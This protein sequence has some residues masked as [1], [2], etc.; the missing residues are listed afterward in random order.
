MLKLLSDWIYSGQIT[1][2]NEYIIDHTFFGITEDYK[3]K[4]HTEIFNFVFQG[5]GGFPYM[6]VYNMPISI[7]NFYFTQLSDVLTKREQEAQ[8][9]KNRRRSR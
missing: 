4:I 1:K 7:R 8:K 5:Q 3:R 6:D 9:T 2:G